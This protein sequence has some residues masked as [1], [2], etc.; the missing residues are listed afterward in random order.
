MGMTVITYCNFAIG[1]TS[2]PFRLTKKQK[3][4]RDIPRLRLIFSTRVLYRWSAAVIA[5]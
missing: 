2:S 5:Y 4:F 1:T 3:Q